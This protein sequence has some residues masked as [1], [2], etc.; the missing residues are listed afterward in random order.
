MRLDQNPVFRKVIVPWYDSDAACFIVIICM[1]FVLLFGFAGFSVAREEAGYHAH[2]WV[3]AL[4]VA[5]CAG[6]I[7]STVIRLTKRYIRR[8]SK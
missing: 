8:Y 4:L 3:P 6:V 2:I 1:G 7:V 5:M